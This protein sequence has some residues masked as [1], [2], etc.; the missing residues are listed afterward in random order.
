[1]S[2]EHVFCVLASFFLMVASGSANLAGVL[3]LESAD[4]FIPTDH[5]Q[6]PLE[7][8]F[9][10][11][12]P[13]ECD[14][15]FQCTNGTLSHEYCPNGLLFSQTGHVVGMCAYYWNVDCQGRNIR[16]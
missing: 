8:V 4:A 16:K 5:S 10:Y 1:M 9:G 6:C 12:H 2:I 3:P 15:Y 14:Q 13:K 11:P 7:G